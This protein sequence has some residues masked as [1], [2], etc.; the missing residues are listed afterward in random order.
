MT[1]F[2][3]R[4]VVVNG[5]SY[6]YRVHVPQRNVARPV[7][8]VL[9]LHGGGERGDDGD[10]HVAVGLGAAIARE[11]ERF[12]LI[13]VFP[14]CRPEYIGFCGDMAVVALGALEQATL[15]FEADRRRTYLTGLSMGA[16]SACFLAVS[17]PNRFAA[18]ALVCGSITFAPTDDPPELPHEDRPLFRSMFRAADRADFIA[19]RLRHVPVWMFHGSDDSISPPEDSRSLARSLTRVG[20]EVRYTEYAGL[21]HESWDR[22]YAEPE[23]LPWLLSQHREP[24]LGAPAEE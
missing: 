7:P 16:S 2:A 14:Q 12:P 11:P 21:G 13:G 15:E 4:T 5:Q 17:H 10:R 3:R 1:A 19:R 9:D 8:I 23:L 6:S 18:M 22:A 20:A 24:S